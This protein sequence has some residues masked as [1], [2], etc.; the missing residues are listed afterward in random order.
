M[1]EREVGKEV[2]VMIRDEAPIEAVIRRPFLSWCLIARNCAK[3]LEATLKSLRER[4]PEAEIVVVD[5]MSGDEGATWRVAEEY[6]DII[7]TYAGPNH[8]WAPEMVAFDDAAAARNFSFSLALGDWIGWDAP[9]ATTAAAPRG[10]GHGAPALAPKPPP[11][12]IVSSR[13]TRSS[14]RRGLIKAAA[15]A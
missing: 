4:T 2:K 13:V 1:E 10:G 6:A 14:C 15:W 12:A 8:D 7:T 9:A 11:L 3:T 5:T